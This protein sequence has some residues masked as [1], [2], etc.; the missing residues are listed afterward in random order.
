MAFSRSTKRP[1]KARPA[2]DKDVSLQVMVPA[3]VKRDVSV[4]AAKEG[5]T[6]RTIILTALRAIGFEVDENDLCDKRKVRK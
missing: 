5:S 6:Q 4:Q 1:D 3:R 2:V